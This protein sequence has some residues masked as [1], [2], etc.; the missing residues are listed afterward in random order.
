MP[1]ADV[2]P[3]RRGN[4]FG[5]FTHSSE[6]TIAMTIKI[7]QW[8]FEGPYNT[9]AAVWNRSGAY[10]ILTRP[11]GTATYRVV[12]AGESGDLRARLD[13]HDRADCWRR[14][15]QGDLAVAVLYCDERSRKAVEAH[16]R[17]AYAPACGVR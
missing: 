1:P 11:A 2:C 10:A 3:H 12:D 4:A 14:N 15:N 13:T 8:D 16:L 9:T 6:S 17:A 7:D 5:G